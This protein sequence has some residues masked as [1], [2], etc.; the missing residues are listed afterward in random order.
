MQ[1]DDPLSILNWLVEAGADEAVSEMPV[2]RLTAKPASPTPM[3]KK[4]AVP[5]FSP[6]A[7]AETSKALA[8]SD[9]ISD[10]IAAAA[11]AT[12]LAELKSAL[13]NFDGCA[14]KRTATNTV[15]ADG[16][17]DAGI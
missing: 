13:E 11:A 15:F 10:A 4:P 3:A 7:R 1:A 2:N 16:V 17:P 8:S 9:G 12:S 5:T 6:P 14:L